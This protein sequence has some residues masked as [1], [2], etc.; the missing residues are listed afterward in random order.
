METKIETEHFAR[1]NL[2][3]AVEIALEGQRDLIVSG[4]GTEIINLH[5]DYRAILAKIDGESAGVIVWSVQEWISDAFIHLGYVRKP[6]RRRGVYRALW[7]AL[8]A[9]ARDKELVS[10][11]GVTDTNNAQLRNVALALGRVERSVGLHF[12][13]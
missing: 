8:L 6:F 4:M 7:N 11:S 10:V 5:G 1:L 9:T 2:T 12:K 3:P 13:L